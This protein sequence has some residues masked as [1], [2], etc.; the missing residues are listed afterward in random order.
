MN[1]YVNLNILAVTKMSNNVCIVG[2]DEN[3]SWMRPVK[4]AYSNPSVSD[5][6]HG[7]QCVIKTYN[8]VSFLAN[9]KLTNYPHSEDFIANWSFKKPKF[10]KGLNLHERNELFFNIDESEKINED[11]TSYLLENNRSLILI[12]PNKIIRC[13]WINSYDNKYKPRISFLL[14]EKF[15][16]FPCTDLGWRAI[17]RYYNMPKCVDLLNNNDVYF[18]IGLSRKFNEEF[19]PMI[20]GVHAIPEIEIEINYSNL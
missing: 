13:S 11:I 1:E 17:G 19:W 15:Y 6:F 20:V 12:K 14:N 2:V 4:S 5:I 9:N 18:V 3:N 10:I 16:N 8:V 7:N